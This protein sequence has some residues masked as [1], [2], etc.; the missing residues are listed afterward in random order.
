MKKFFASL[1][2]ICLLL[3]ALLVGCGDTSNNQNPEKFGLPCIYIETMDGKLPKNKVDYVNCSFAITN[4]ADEDDSFSVEMKEAYGDE[5]SVGIRLR[6]NTTM[7]YKKKPYRIK[8]DKKKSLF[9]SKKNKNWVLLADYLDPSDMRNYTAH[10][11]ARKYEGLDFVV[12]THHVVLSLNGEFKGVYLLTDQVD[13]KEGR[14]NV[15]CDFDAEKDVDFPFLIEMSQDAKKGNVEGVDYFSVDGYQPVEIKYPEADERDSNGVVYN[16]IVGYMKA[17]CALLDNGNKPIE[18][19]FRGKS[20]TVTLADLVDEDSLIDYL[21][22]NEIIGN[23]DSVWKSINMH[24]SQ[25]GKLVFGP[26]WDFDCAAIPKWKGRPSQAKNDLNI[27]NTAF[28]LH[29]V[30]A[31]KWLAIDGNKQKLYDR[32]METRHYILEMVDHLAEYKSYISAAAKADAKLWYGRKGEARFEEQYTFLQN[33]LMIRY[34]SLA[35]I[36]NPENK[37]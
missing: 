24:K 3:S 22:V 35:T 11:L 5:D 30:I 16:Y 12:S 19:N 31:A 29:G 15:E 34:A 2:T 4:T 9:G 18:V 36:L 6:G 8:F 21:L 28:T 7:R 20:E 14:T 23:A 32:F 37:S 33:F 17:V 1:L 26:V 13:E 27:A 10:T 25:N